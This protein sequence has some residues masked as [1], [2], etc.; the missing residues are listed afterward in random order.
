MKLDVCCG[1]SVTNVNKKFFGNSKR[2]KERKRCKY[3]IRM[4]DGR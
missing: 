1:V 2:G 3:E 4:A